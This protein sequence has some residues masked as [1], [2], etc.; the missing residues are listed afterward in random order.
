M[1]LVGFLYI[2]SW[3]IPL[4]IIQMTIVAVVDNIHK[5]IQVMQP[6]HFIE[7]DGGRRR[8]RKINKKNPKTKQTLVF[9][10]CGAVKLLL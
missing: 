8:E 3:S 5:L 2:S 9:V 7:Q 1:T 10:T 6:N 4:R